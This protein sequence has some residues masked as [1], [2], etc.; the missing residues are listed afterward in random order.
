MI[1]TSMYAAIPILGDIYGLVVKLMGLVMD[2][3]YK[4]TCF[5]DAGGTSISN[6]GL[7]IIIFTIVVNIFMV[8]LTLKQ[9][10]SSRLMSVM[11]PEINAIQKKYKGKQDNESMIRMQT[12]V[13]AVY[14]KYGTNM[15]GGC[16]QIIIQMIFLFAL[17]QVIYRIPEYVSSVR[18]IYET[19]A[20]P[21]M[22]IDGYKETL[23]TLVGEWSISRMTASTD[24]S[25]MTNVVDFL[26]KLTPDNWAALVEYFP[27][28]SSEITATA[29]ISISLNYFLGLNL[30]TIPWQGLTP[31]PAWILPV[32]SGLTQWVSAKM[33]MSRQASANDENNAM[34]QQMSTMTTMMPIMSVVFCFT[35]PAGL[36]VYWVAS[37]VCRIVQQFFINRYLSS[38]DMDEM[39]RSN[40]EKANI[41]REKRGL[42]PVSYDKNA[43]AN[44]EE[45]Y[46]RLEESKQTKLAK[47][48]KQVK[49]SSEYYNLN[50]KPGSIAAKANMVAMYDKRQQEKKSRKG[51]EESKA[52]DSTAG[53]ESNESSDIE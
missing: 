2:Q 31:N 25:S 12:E 48:V 40:V 51:R 38:I 28:L 44:Y 18:Q 3:I 29:D 5:F 24:F 20:T 49:D 10:K 41:K 30:S 13:R 7:C 46:Q 14:E 8:P 16:V 17:Y 4:L 6:I 21:L 9:Q 19:V 42:K 32:L 52:V 23:S 34:A 37:A 43:V 22:T 39:I 47:A 50:A 53:T 33:M 26:Y 35:L 27:T 36:G 1:S 45:E 11:Q 15:T